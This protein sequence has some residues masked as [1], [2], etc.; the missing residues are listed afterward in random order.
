MSFDLL[1]KQFDDYCNE[2]AD[3]EEMDIEKHIK[4]A[5]KVGELLRE[6]ERLERCLTQLGQDW[7]NVVDERNVLKEKVERYEKALQKIIEMESPFYF[8]ETAL[9]TPY[10]YAKVA[11]ERK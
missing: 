5:F 10:N 9:E 3:T 4:M 2:F 11:L 8:R 6:N 1:K 7:S